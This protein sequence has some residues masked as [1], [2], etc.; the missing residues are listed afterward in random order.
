MLL[1]PSPA[2]DYHTFSDPSPFERDVPYG[3]PLCSCKPDDYFLISSPRQLTR[4]PPSKASTSNSRG[5]SAFLIREPATVL[6]SPNHM[7]KTLEPSSVTLKLS[8]SKLT[9]FSIY[10]PSNSSASDN[11]S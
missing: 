4:K 6:D 7:Y 2:K 9:I 5:G 1:H 10:R 3:R 11:I 8:T